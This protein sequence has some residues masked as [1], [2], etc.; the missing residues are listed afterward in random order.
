IIGGGLEAAIV[1]VKATHAASLTSKLDS[2]ASSAA[3]AA[4]GAGGQVIAGNLV[5]NAVVG[6]ANASI[7]CVQSGTPITTAAGDISVEADDASSLTATD[8]MLS[9]Q[10]TTNDLLFGVVNDVAQKLM[11]TYEFTTLSGTR[12]LKFGDT[13]YVD[14]SIYKFMG[15]SASD[16]DL[17]TATYTDL[18]LWKL[19]SA[20]TILPTS[21][22][23]VLST[24]ASFKGG[25]S[26]AKAGM[27][28]R[29]EVE[30][31]AFAW[32]ED[33]TLTAEGNITVRAAERA[34]LNAT[35]LSSVTAKEATTFIIATN[36]V[37]AKAEA[38]VRS[39]ILKT[40]DTN[41]DKEHSIM[42]EALNLLVANA[43]MNLTAESKLDGQDKSDGLGLLFAF[44]TVGYEAN[45]IFFQAAEALIGNDY[46]TDLVTDR[47]TY[48]AAAFADDSDLIA[49]HDVIVR[50]ESRELAGTGSL[51]SSVTAQA[52]NDLGTVDGDQDDEEQDAAFAA[53]LK[54]SMIA[55]GAIADD[56]AEE[57]PVTLTIETLAAD[58][59]WY[60]I[61]SDGRIWQVLAEDNGPGGTVLNVY[62]A[63]LLNARVGNDVAV[64]AKN[65]RVLVD[66]LVNQNKLDK[67]RAAAEKKGEEFK[68][69]LKYGSNAASAG[70]VLASNKVNSSTQ[71]WIRGNAFRYSSDETVS[72][73]RDGDV[74][75]VGDTLYRY[76]GPDQVRVTDYDHLSIDV[77]TALADGDTIRISATLASNDD[78]T[79]FKAGEIYT[80]SGAGGAD[81]DLETL[82]G[83]D[84]GDFTLANP[85]LSIDL[86]DA[87]QDYENN[88]AQWTDLGTGQ[89]YE[90]TAETGEVSVI[91]KDTAN[92]RVTTSLTVSAEAT[93]NVDAFKQIAADLTKSDYDYTTESG[94][95]DIE[96]GDVVRIGDGPDGPG[97]DYVGQV[98]RFVGDADADDVDLSNFVLT[99]T[100]V[101]N[102]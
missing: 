16:V 31:G 15:D 40:N 52:L 24:V 96:Q 8:A 79:T 76:T 81:I 86:S 42:V 25:P 3:A 50:A 17:A 94:V 59:Q 56:S 26:K 74:V 55:I 68:G 93:N 97:A 53:Q 90:V 87:E 46:L 44:N 43:D 12:D 22:A 85:E 35:E 18:D 33:A 32:V 77:P 57:N 58:A 38:Y 20:T 75:Q 88:T 62:L 47:N 91:A 101:Q 82:L 45:N 84:P 73:L 98:Y 65:D 95:Q 54:T 23:K 89:S 61:A 28:T 14:G 21:V 41:G 29:N 99:G 49:D 11:D 92:L 2:N 71:A 37:L 39:S 80:Y 78:S 4:K 1:T 63:N 10:S 69:K 83:T 102:L 67:D 51:D 19:M 66:R 36:S 6:G 34:I 5:S 13:V 70:G 27:I 48:G 100:G 7:T 64:K 60:V 9:A 30:G 72:D